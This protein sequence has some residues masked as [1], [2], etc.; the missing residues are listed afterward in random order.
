MKMLDEMCEV[1]L[2]EEVVKLKKENA[3]LKDA[4]IRVGKAIDSGDITYASVI[5]IAN[6]HLLE[7]REETKNDHTNQL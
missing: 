7:I 4:L 1:E 2:Q 6:K 3:W 5:I